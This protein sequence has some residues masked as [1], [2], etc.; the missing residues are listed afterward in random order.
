M[1]PAIHLIGSRYLLIVATAALIGDVAID[2]SPAPT[3]VDVPIDA[4][5]IVVASVTTVVPA[6][7]RWKHCDDCDGE[8]GVALWQQPARPDE[9]AYDPRPDDGSLSKWEIVGAMSK[10]KGDVYDC[11]ARFQVPGLAIAQV[12]TTASGRETSA[13]VTGS[14][15]GTPTGACVEKE[16]G[17]QSSRERRAQRPSPTRS[18]SGRRST[19]TRRFHVE[20]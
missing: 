9:V 15:A 14:F 18:C 4:P 1:T 6:K 17:A 2:R 7:H 16:P 20:D 10:T 19:T 8:F 5:P 12:T 11:F 13:V 3:P